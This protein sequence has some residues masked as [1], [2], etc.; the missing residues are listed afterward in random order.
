[1]MVDYIRTPTFGSASVIFVKY[2]AGCGFAGIDRAFC[3]KR[4]P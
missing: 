4:D 3:R 2:D 1:M